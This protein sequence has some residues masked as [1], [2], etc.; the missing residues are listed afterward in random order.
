MA[1]I[2]PAKTMSAEGWI[3]TGILAAT[4]AAFAWGHLRPEIVAMA[5]VLALGLSGVAA[6][7]Q[8]FAGFG[9]PVVITIA[10]LFVVSAGLERTGMAVR[11]ARS[12]IGVLGSPSEVTLTAALMVLAGLL[13]GIMNVIGAMAMLLP[14]ALAVCRETGISPTRLLMPLAIGS[15][16]GGALTLIGKPSNLI[17]NAFLVD[18][19][20]PSL[21]FFSFL[22]V[23]VALLAVGAAFMATAG[24]RLLPAQADGPPPAGRPPRALPEVYQIRERLFRIRVDE[25][26]PLAGKTLTEASLGES[27]GITVL[28][29]TRGRRRLDAPVPDERLQPGDVLLVAA[30]AEEVERLRA[31]GP[32]EAEPDVGPRTVLET[33]EVGLAEVMVA[34]RSDLAGKSLRELEFRRRYGLTVVA[35][36]HAGRPRRTWL[37]DL[38]LEYG[39]ALL[40][41]GPRERI[42]VLREDPNFI[43]LD[44]PPPLRIGRAPFALL[45]AAALVVLGAAGVAP[46]SLVALLAAGLVVAGGGVT[47]EEA[48]QSIDWRT[49]VVTGGLLPLGLALHATGAAAVL[50][51]GILAVGGHSGAGTLAAVL[52]AAVVVGHFVPSVPATILMAPI[53]LS[54]AVAVGAS[55]VPFMITVASATSVTLLTPI[56]HPASLMVMG[57]GGYRFTDYTRVGAP[58]ALLLALTL[59]AVVALVWGV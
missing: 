1:E 4:L 58:L 36:W 8:A 20:F 39:D 45:A 52:A 54:A 21:S 34:P 29:I 40:L 25:T 35:I 57:P 19:G 30:R 12:L 13:S 38:P 16:L 11:A 28:R 53:A 23:G 46:I 17:A 2:S 50:A 56:S 32:L 59:L 10:C 47:V 48:F 24:R 22:P 9:D 3:A 51:E 49:V 26:A 14:V 7:A 6:P 31:L 18:A 41:Q 43:S 37:A 44:V 33:D 5:A 55:P 15:R 27:F 42:E